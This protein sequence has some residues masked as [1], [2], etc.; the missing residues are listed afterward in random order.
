[1]R[2]VRRA[3]TA[4]RRVRLEGGDRPAATQR[5]A[6]RTRES[7][8]LGRHRLDDDDVADRDRA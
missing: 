1:M 4:R 6:E 8:R 7:R 2:E 5:E 3:D